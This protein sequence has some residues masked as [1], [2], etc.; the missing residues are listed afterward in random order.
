MIENSYNLYRENRAKVS[1]GR[2]IPAVRRFGAMAAEVLSG[3]QNSEALGLAHTEIV[4][5][6]RDG[7]NGAGFGKWELAQR[8]SERR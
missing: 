3:S 6:A 4:F 7:L 8:V 1:Q 5:R 2:N